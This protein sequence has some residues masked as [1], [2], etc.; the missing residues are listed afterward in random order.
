[1]AAAFAGLLTNRDFANVLPGLV[2]EP[3]RAGLVMER[4]KALSDVHRSTK[5]PSP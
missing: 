2:A 1:V 5:E 3:E 4:L